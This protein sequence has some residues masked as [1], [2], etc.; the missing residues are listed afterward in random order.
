MK[1]KIKIVECGEEYIQEIFNKMDNSRKYD[2]MDGTLFRIKGKTG[3]YE[4]SE[5]VLHYCFAKERL[6]A[7]EALEAMRV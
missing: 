4:L 5:T 3:I 6:T 2:S 1:K 7:S